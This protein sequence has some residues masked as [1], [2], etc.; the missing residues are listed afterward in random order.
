MGILSS[1][2]LVTENLLNAYYMLEIRLDVGEQNRVKH[3]PVLE[4]F[5]QGEY[6]NRPLTPSTE[7][8]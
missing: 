2:P 5:A 4:D 7:Q 8:S 3:C 6:T 1:L